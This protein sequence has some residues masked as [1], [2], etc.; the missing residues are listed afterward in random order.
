MSH[1]LVENLIDKLEVSVLHDLY[2]PTQLE[3]Y[4]W[5][6]LLVFGLYYKVKYH[7]TGVVVSCSDHLQGPTTEE[8]VLDNIVICYFRWLFVDIVE[9]ELHQ[10]LEL[11]LKELL[12][13]KGRDLPQ[14]FGDAF[15]FEMK[16]HELN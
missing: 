4:L 2:H 13:L 15:A 7:C 14:W 5:S 16:G 10:N 11:D 1:F 6:L 12:D 3:L 8:Q 9:N